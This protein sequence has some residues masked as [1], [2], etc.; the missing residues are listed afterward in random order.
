MLPTADLA[1]LLGYLAAIV[2]LGL[3]L[4]RRVRDTNQFMAAGRAM[5]GWA[6]GLSM[7]G[8]YISS[9]SF[10]ANPGKAYADNWNAVAFTLA[11][12][13]A[14]VVAVRWFVPFYL[15]E[16]AVS[17]YQHLERRYGRWAR[18]YAVVCFL[19]YQMARMGSIVYLVA[20]AMVPLTGWSKSSTIITTGALMTA[21]MLAG[22]MKAVVWVGVLQSA[23]LIVGTL[24]CLVAVVLKTPG[25]VPGILDAA[26]AQHKF[27]LGS[28]G[29]SLA[30]STFWVVFVYGV[31]MNLSNFGVDQ[32]YVQRYITARSDRDAKRS[33]WLTT[34]LY[35][36]VAPIFFFIGTSLFVFY[37]A[38]PDLLGTGLK[39][40]QV[41]PHFISTQLPAG[42]AGLVVAAIFAASMDSNLS[43]MATLTLCDLYKPYWRPD[44][45]E[46]QSLRVLRWSTLGWGAAGTAVGLGMI[47]VDTALDA[48]WNLAGLFSGGVLGLLLL[49]L[50][51]R[52]A[53]PTAGAAAVASGVVV[54]AWM[55]LPSLRIDLP[56]LWRNPMHAN[57]TIV[58]GTLTIFLVG[59]IVGLF[60]PE[61]SPASCPEF[62]PPSAGL[63]V[64][65][66]Q[67]E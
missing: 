32:S 52:R 50:L 25:G 6:I 34:L 12:P 48:W 61:P 26:A 3:W 45:T 24:A 44:A 5:P 63:A 2:G 7:F 64:Q 23:V 9:I 31:V 59:A 29:P 39:P 54:M 16:G 38:R 58:V 8:S 4:G 41:F 66:G 56:G 37:A 18:T 60:K 28:F 62:A 40:D 1:I 19:L 65:P 33:V 21:Y 46:R 35:V 53:G 17:A 47:R 20:L 11:T 51:F 22:G 67:H 10:L 27:D 49:S 42:L 13:I 57:M 43:S 36:P 15:R 55:A 30:Q 14:A